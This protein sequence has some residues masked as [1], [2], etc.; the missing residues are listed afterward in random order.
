AGATDEASAV[1]IQ[2]DGKI[3]VV[4]KALPGVGGIVTDIAVVRLTAN[5]QL[6][7]TFDGD[8]K[9]IIAFDLVPNGQDLATA[10]VVQPDGKILIAGTVQTQTSP[11]QSQMALVRLNPNGSFD[12]T[13]DG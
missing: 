11:F 7:P 1:A 8:G 9:K 13:F 10:L 2:P 3:V 12:S 6:D 4:G 5:G